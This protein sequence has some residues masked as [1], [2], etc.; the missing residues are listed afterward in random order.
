MTR[1]LNANNSKWLRASDIAVVWT[2]AQRA[3]DQRFVDWLVANFNADAFGV[4]SVCP[5]PATLKAALAASYHCNDGQHRLCAVKIKFGDDYLVP[6]SVSPESDPASAARM[7]DRLQARNKPHAIDIF[8][9]R[10]TAEFADEQTVARTL[11][12]IGF[13]VGN[14]LA[15]DTVRAIGAVLD[16]Y[17]LGGDALLRRT[18]LIARRLWGP[19]PIAY[20]GP[21]IKGLSLFL[22]E[23]GAKVDE[24]RLGATVGK[25]LTAQRLM[26]HARA[27]RE[28]SPNRRGGLPASVAFLLVETYNGGLRGQNRL[29][30]K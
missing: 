14:Y 26:A 2:E 25:N 22:N 23:H 6:C 27:H 16:I 20:D 21:L 4:L 29:G 30:E 1:H 8:R 15:D 10:V 18:L 9:V 12:E 3:L 11:D 13:K 19:A 5:V 28:I 17:R 7:F 24:R